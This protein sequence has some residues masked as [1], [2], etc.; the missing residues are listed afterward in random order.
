VDRITDFATGEGIGLEP[1]EYSNETP[2]SWM[3]TMPN[4]GVATNQKFF[5][6]QGNL[7]GNQFTVNSST[8]TDTLVVYDGDSTGGVTQTG[9]VL[10]GVTLTQLQAYTGGN[11]IS[12]S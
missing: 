4:N 2:L 6:V 1:P 10:S 9:I 11:W 3:G 8:G 7:A 5:M 12:H